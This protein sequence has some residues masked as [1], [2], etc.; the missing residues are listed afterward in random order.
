MLSAQGWC[1]VEVPVLGI[2]RSKE[3][4]VVLLLDAPGGILLLI[5]VGPELESKFGTWGNEGHHRGCSFSA[6][7]WLTQRPCRKQMDQ[8]CNEQAHMSHHCLR[9]EEII[10]VGSSCLSFSPW[11]LSWS[12]P[13]AVETLILNRL[14][15]SC[16]FFLANVAGD[17]F[18]LL[19]VTLLRLLHWIFPSAFLAV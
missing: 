14:F 6:S 10:H 17:R 8:P 19:L 5:C 11:F 7:S 15:S 16:V 4:W 3:I 18:C 12:S 2:P 1:C 9:G 13:G